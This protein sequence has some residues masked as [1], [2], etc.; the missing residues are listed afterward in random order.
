MSLRVSAQL[1]AAEARSWD[2]QTDALDLVAHQHS[3]NTEPNPDLGRTRLVLA[4]EQL[5][6]QRAR[7]AA[8]REANPFAT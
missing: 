6:G 5:G 7:A 8:P 3:A 1:A 4:I 2:G